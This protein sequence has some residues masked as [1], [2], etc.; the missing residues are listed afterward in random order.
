[1][2]IGGSPSPPPVV[3]AT[4]PPPVPKKTD[5]EVKKAKQK[6]ISAAALAQGRDGTLLGGQLSSTPSN[7]ASKK[8]LGA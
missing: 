1:M 4:P 2:C 7:S 8:L 3:A 5:P 6:S